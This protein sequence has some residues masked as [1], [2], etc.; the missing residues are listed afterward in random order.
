MKTLNIESLARE[1]AQIRAALEITERL[2]T[3]GFKAYF[4]G[5]CIRDWLL[6]GA[7]KD[8]DIAT[9]ALPA[10]TRHY[11]EGG[12]E[13]GEAFGVT[14]VKRSGFTFEVATFRSDG[15]YGDGRRPDTVELHKSPEEDAKRRDFTV[16]ALFLD[17]GTGEVIDYVGGV[18]DLEAGV[19]RAVGVPEERFAEDYLRML[20]AVRF[21]SRLGFAIEEKTFS[22]I[23]ENRKKI[24]KIAKERILTEIEKILTSD[25]SLS[26]GWRLLVELDILRLL[27][28]NLEGCSEQRTM[29]MLRRLTE[30]RVLKP[31]PFGEVYDSVALAWAVVFHPLDHSIDI[32]L[33]SW[34][35]SNELRNRIISLVKH[36]RH[37][38]FSVD[39]FS[40]ARLSTQKRMLR[41]P[42]LKEHL[43]LWTIWKSKSVDVF[44]HESVEVFDPV[45]HVVDVEM[46]RLNCDK[47]RSLRPS[48]LL[49]GNDLQELGYKPGPMFSQMLLA[50]EEEQLM[51][52][53]LSKE[54][55]VQFVLEN[56]TRGT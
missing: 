45:R 49:D 39:N 4:A 48:A 15:S 12:P 35:M 3:F 16:N 24:L 43:A 51:E 14:L 13:V 1:D 20:R 34:P 6:G 52:R 5:G 37:D 7:P 30:L 11:C 54:E 56:F 22:A 31:V 28:P 19:I 55:A 23:K 41:R 46:A 33:E 38:D 47:A 10:D 42:C 17:T 32:E 40:S 8:I 26:H 53:V 36:L 18:K 9:D 25:V 44:D 27:F 21:A 2:R 29:D 50:L